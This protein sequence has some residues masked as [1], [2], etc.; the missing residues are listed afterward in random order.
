M[1]PNLPPVL[2]GFPLEVGSTVELASGEIQTIT[3]IK[4]E[5]AYG[6]HPYYHWY[7]DTGVIS[8]AAMGDEHRIVRHWPPNSPDAPPIARSNGIVGEPTTAPCESESPKPDELESDLA[9]ARAEKAEI[10]Q[11]WNNQK[12]HITAFA[13]CLDGIL[14]LDQKNAIRGG[15]M[16]GYRSAQDITAI[17]KHLLESNERLRAALEE[18]ESLEPDED[19]N[20]N[21]NDLVACQAVEIA[22]A[23]LAP[24]SSGKG[25]G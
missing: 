4:H 10:E 19:H 20:E 16:D 12:T 1:T 6:K 15:G 21:R 9:A 24:A 13:Q 5:E 7:Q 25:E 2:P 3:E 22:R 18:I 23:V 11:K 14:T 8:H 17:V